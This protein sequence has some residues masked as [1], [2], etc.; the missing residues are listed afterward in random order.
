MEYVKLSDTLQIS[1]LVAGFMRAAS[2]GAKGETLLSFIEKCLDMGIT[3]FDH[4]DI[5]GAYQ[6][7][8]LFGE[9]LAIKPAL[10]KKMQL[11]TKCNI[12]LDDPSKNTIYHYNTSKKHIISSLES[13]LRNLNTDYID[14]LLIHRQDPLMNPYEVADAFD[15]L[16][17]DGKVKNFG[18]SNFT[19]SGFNM[20]DSVLDLPLVTNQIEISAVHPQAFFD[21]STDHGMEKRIPLMAWSPLGGGKVFNP[22]FRDYAGLR[23]VLQEIALENN[24]DSID[25]ILYAFLLKH[26][27]RICPII[28]SMKI[29]RIKSGV[30]ALDISLTR[31]QWFSILE[32]S[33]GFRMP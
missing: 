11:V 12:V 27:A 29:S 9:A 33:R 30:D 25:K 1:R 8:A 28:G 16:Y 7:E 2:A 5:Y 22:D 24:I 23:N 20:L 26:P 13:S 10:R 19:P 17:K 31:E 32:A 15:T 3:T 21:G 14:L 4:A 6:C 18:V